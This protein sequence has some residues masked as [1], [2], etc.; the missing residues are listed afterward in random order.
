MNSALRTFFAALI[1]LSFA[2]C[3]TIGETEKAGFLSDY[4]KLEEGPDGQPYYN[5]GKT[6]QYSKFMVDPVVLLFDPEDSPFTREELQELQEYFHA[7]VT[8]RLSENDGYEAYA[9]P[10]PGVARI[11]I[12]ITDVEKTVGAL[13]VLIWTELTW[14]SIWR[15]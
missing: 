10:G 7:A 2:G 8:D 4:S 1:L 13:N 5:A 15:R 9:Q 6:G 11:R 14:S 12:G 3:S